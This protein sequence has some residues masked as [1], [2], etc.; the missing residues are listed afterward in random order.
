MRRVKGRALALEHKRQNGYSWRGMA[1][2]CEHASE[3]GLPDPQFYMVFEDAETGERR[4]LDNQMLCLGEV[5]YWAELA[6]NGGCTDKIGYVN[7]LFAVDKSN[8]N[9]LCYLL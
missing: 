5:Y 6:R 9:V 2:A 1:L 8:L 3:F 4:L 7:A